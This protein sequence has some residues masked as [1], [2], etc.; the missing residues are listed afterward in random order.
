M[1]KALIATCLGWWFLTAVES[2][3][4]QDQFIVVVLDDSGSMHG[5]MRTEQ[6][7]VQKIDA[8]K[9]ALTS[10]LSN[11]PPG[12]DVGVLALNSQVDR[13]HWVVPVGTGT[14]GDWRQSIEQISASGGTPLGERMKEAA[15]QLLELRAAQ[16]YGLY[17]M[18]VVTDGEAN[19]QWL[20]DGYLP[21][22]LSRGIMVDVIGVDMDGNHS[23]ATLVHSYRRADDDASLQSAISEVFG[24]TPTDD[25]AAASDFELIGGLPDDV[26]VAALNALSRI[27]NDPIAT[28]EMEYVVVEPDGTTTRRSVASPTPS[29]S[30]GVSALVGGALCCLGG[31]AA[32]FVLIAAIAIGQSRRRRR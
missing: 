1:Q 21:D 23:L 26:A 29:R 28:V 12:T 9:Q 22:I 17:R 3:I 18:L 27:R 32:I 6:G 2:A 16:T 5:F 7:S 30:S 14:P 10:V 4:G 19:D 24:E 31:F 8:A 15:D 11:L 20:L 13:S 25:A